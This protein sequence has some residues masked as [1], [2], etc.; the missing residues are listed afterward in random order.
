MTLRVLQLDLG[1][2]D[3]PQ[4]QT[5][6]YRDPS[7]G[8]YY[9]YNAEARQ[10]YIYTAGYLVPL[11]VPKEPAPKVVNIA[12]GDTLRIEYSYRYCGPAISVTEYASLGYTTLGIYDE[13]VSKGKSRS[14]PL[15]T[16]PTTFTGYIDLVMPTPAQTK[17]NDIECKVFNGGEELGINYQDALNVVAVDAEFTEFSIIDY[18]KL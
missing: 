2:L 3:P 14:L 6:W 16:T 4:H 12:A 10:W 17:W 18:S 8:Q 15:S 5:G 1:V 13:I 11:S 7:T 9:Y